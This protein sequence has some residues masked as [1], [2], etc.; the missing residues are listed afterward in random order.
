VWPPPFELID[1]AE[2][3]PVAPGDEEEPWSL[4]AA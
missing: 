1:E 4:L 3:G 2:R